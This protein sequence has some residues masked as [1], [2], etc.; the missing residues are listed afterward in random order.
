MVQTRGEG[1]GEGQ[2]NFILYTFR[3]EIRV[4]RIV[5]FTNPL[6]LVVGALVDTQNVL[7]RDHACAGSDRGGPL[8]RLPLGPHHIADDV[9]RVGGVEALVTVPLI[10]RAVVAGTAAVAAACCLAGEMDMGNNSVLGVNLTTR[11][12]WSREQVSRALS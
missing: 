9:D 11:T 12:S 1:L 7:L 2:D 5:P 8:R 10:C 6:D 4:A 3:Y